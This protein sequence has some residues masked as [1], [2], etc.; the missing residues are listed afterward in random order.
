MANS[1]PWALFFNGVSPARRRREPESADRGY[2]LERSQRLASQRA[3]PR[4][5]QCVRQ[6]RVPHAFQ[7]GATTEDLSLERAALPGWT[8]ARYFQRSDVIAGG[9]STISMRSARV[10]LG[11]ARVVLSAGSRR[12]RSS[13]RSPGKAS[14]R[15]GVATLGP[16]PLTMDSVRSNARLV[17]RLCAQV[18]KKS[19][20]FR[21]QPLAQGEGG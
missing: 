12:Q 19:N 10:R 20:P 2:A 11:S 3:P 21:P 4:R 16:G 15:P 8:H 17:A 1:L 9:C 18:R 5:F 7:R 13:S 6:S 14:C